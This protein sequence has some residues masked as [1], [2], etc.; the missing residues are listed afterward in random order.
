[1]E[2]L[3]IRQ[4]QGGTALV[5]FDGQAISIQIFLRIPVEIKVGRMAVPVHCA[6]GYELTAKEMEVMDMIFDGR[7]DKEISERLR[8]S[9]RTAKFHVSNILRK[10]GC[11]NRTDL[12]LTCRARGDMR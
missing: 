8:M 12:A 6:G 11:K 3:E 9:L 5:D 1:M 10:A 4:I 7:T 2:K